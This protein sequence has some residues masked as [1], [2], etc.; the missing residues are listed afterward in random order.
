MKLIKEAK[1]G[2]QF[3]V[4]DTFCVINLSRITMIFFLTS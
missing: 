4:N 2:A 1:I 3:D